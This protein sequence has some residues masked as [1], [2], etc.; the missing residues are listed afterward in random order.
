MLTLLIQMI[1]DEKDQLLLHYQANDW[2]ALYQ[3]NHKIYGG[4]S[5]CG[6]PNLLDASQRLESELQTLIHSGEK[7]GESKEPQAHTNLQALLDNLI[8]TIDELTKW[9][10]EHD[11][12]I[13]FELD[14]YT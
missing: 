12:A 8:E 2:D 10:N 5:Y 4:C 1:K 7:I 11:T 14:D 9:D 13:V 6:T 3:L